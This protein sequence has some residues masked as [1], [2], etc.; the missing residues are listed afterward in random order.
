MSGRRP[1][2]DLASTDP[3]RYLREL[4]ADGEA[5]ELT[6]AGLGDFYWVVSAVGVDPGSLRA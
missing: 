1:S 5:G 4:A 3:E 6:G 2:L